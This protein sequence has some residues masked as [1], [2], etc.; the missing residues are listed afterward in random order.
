MVPP[1]IA[2]VN[3]AVV[4]S[5]FNYFRIFIYIC[6]MYRQR[7]YSTISKYVRQYSYNKNN[8][9]I[10]III[11]MIITI[12]IILMATTT[13]PLIIMR[14][15]IIVDVV[16]ASAHKFDCFYFIERIHITFKAAGDQTSNQRALTSRNNPSCE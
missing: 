13:I 6:S 10:T 14:M 4:C 12:L 15:I 5:S 2:I 7:V 8:I 1:A 9:I 3:E 11:I 16:I